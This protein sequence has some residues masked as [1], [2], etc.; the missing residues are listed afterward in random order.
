[1]EHS[2]G[3]TRLPAV[4]TVPSWGLF[5]AGNRHRR[6]RG[7]SR[8]FPVTRNAWCRRRLSVTDM[9]QSPM[10]RRIVSICVTLAVFGWASLGGWP[11]SPGVQAATVEL[12][13][14]PEPTW[15]VMD[16]DCGIRVTE[17][18]RT[19]DEAHS[20]RGCERIHFAP[21]RARTFT[22]GT[23]SLRHA[24]SRNSSPGSGSRRTGTGCSSMPA[25]CCHGRVRRT[26]R[27]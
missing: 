19:F 26:G 12:F 7:F 24:L 2:S 4:V 3:V 13:E 5:S 23:T 18:V 15:R 21:G 14:S 1:M 10:D 27:R 8:R 20:G 6:S 11:I 22:W 25:P 17:H 9:E 16:E